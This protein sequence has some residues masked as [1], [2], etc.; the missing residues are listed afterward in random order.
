MTED[1]GFSKG[2][3]GIVAGETGICTVGK[4]GVGLNYRGYSIND[5]AE[6]SNF[7]EV[8]YLLVHGSLPDE[9]QLASYIDLLHEYRKLPNALKAIL[10]VVPKSAT[11]MDVMRT[12]CSVLG[13]IEP[14][15]DF[16]QK[17]EEKFNQ[18]AVGNR[19][20]AIFGPALL[21][22]HH[23]HNHGVRIE[24]QTEKG[25]TVAANF[26]KLLFN[27]GKEPDESLIKAVDISLI[28]YAEH[29]FA[30]STFACRIT[31]ST[32]ADLYSS[33]CSAVGT[34]RGPL[35]GG[36][37]EAA[38][39]LISQFSSP[40]DAEKGIL[41]MLK[42][43]KLIMGFGHRVY[44]KGDPRTKIVKDWAKKLS[45]LKGFGKP[46]LYAIAERIEEVMWREKKLF[47]NLDFYA[48]LVYHQ[49]DVP[50]N[51]FTPIFVISRTSGW[52]AHAIEQRAS[53][54]LIRPN[55]IYIGP[56][57]K[58]YPGKSKF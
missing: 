52:V 43:K 50:T 35:H 19:L 42:S 25:D 51:F 1:K 41:E 55:A 37:N 20:I 31:T 24:G 32:M 45:L 39:V 53:N 49:C 27:N 26:L 48:S 16:P 57:P 56:E 44:R 30:A 15:S 4:E 9:K 10:E 6:Y 22:W 17:K 40:D 11:P 18:Y 2:L 21:Y 58:K 34:L 29:E 8:A 13:N 23:F 47:A 12:I 3:A 54:K 33:V 5:L 38:F 46:K 7:E 36:A 14:E 28:L